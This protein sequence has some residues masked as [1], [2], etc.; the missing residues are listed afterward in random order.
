MATTEA[1]QRKI[2][3]AQELQ[4]IVKTMKALAAVSIH[5]YERAVSALST[6]QKALELG[7]QVLLHHSTLP[8]LALTAPPVWIVFGSDQ[9]MCGRF[10]DQLAHIVADQIQTHGPADHSHRL[11]TVGS[12]LA[13]RLK[14][15]G[16]PAQVSFSVPSS[17][18]GIT[19][20]VQAMV[21][22]LDDWRSPAGPIHVVHQRFLGGSSYQPK[23]FQLYPLDPVWLDHLRRQPWRSRQVPLLTLPPETLFSALF[24]QL[25]FL[26]LYRACAESLASENAS[27]LAAMQMAE[28]NI[29][30]R[31]TT[32]QSEYHQHRQTLVTEELLD[33]IAGFEA[34]SHSPPSA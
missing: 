25:F 9:G 27:R 32:I 18:S 23:T 17:V 1:L 8:A 15:N 28:K 14:D 11:I 34:L 20:M 22:Q 10:N 24:H 26:G 33:I 6:Y 30:D 2:T 29:Q 31:L 16:Y 13:T 19:P 12:R 4:S 3:S 7:L 21:Q 5:Q